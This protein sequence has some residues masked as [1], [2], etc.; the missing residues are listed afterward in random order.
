MYIT[1]KA[2]KKIRLKPIHPMYGRP[3]KQQFI[4]CSFT[5]DGRKLTGGVTSDPVHEIKRLL[6]VKREYIV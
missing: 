4:V 3:Q 5:D 1:V 6:H 2:V